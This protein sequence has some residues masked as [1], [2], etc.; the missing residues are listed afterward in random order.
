MLRESWFSRDCFLFSDIWQDSKDPWFLFFALHYIG[1]S[2][3]S[4]NIQELIIFLK[5]RKN[6]QKVRVL[7]DLLKE[8]PLIKKREKP[9]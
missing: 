4:L 9:S 7:L 5:E 2:T 6:K 1:F 8:Y 3:P